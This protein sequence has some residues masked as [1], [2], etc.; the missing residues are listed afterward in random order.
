M[1]TGSKVA[2]FMTF[3]EE[4]AY[5]FPNSHNIKTMY[6]LAEEWSNMILNGT[7]AISNYAER[8]KTAFWMLSD[9]EIKWIEQRTHHGTPYGGWIRE[10]I[11]E[12]ILLEHREN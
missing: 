4:F 12:K 9:T 5:T 2:F 8:A 11:A 10:V 1:D 7:P 3:E 6:T